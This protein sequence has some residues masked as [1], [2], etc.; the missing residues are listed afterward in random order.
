LSVVQCS[1]GLVI[2]VHFCLLMTAKESVQA[3]AAHVTVG[4]YPH[5]YCTFTD[6]LLNL[7][8]RRFFY[9]ADKDLHS[10]CDDVAKIWPLNHSDAL[11]LSSACEEV[12]EVGHAFTIFYWAGGS[13]C[14]HLHY[15]MMIPLY[16]ALY[17]DTPQFRG[18]DSEHVFMPTVETVRLQVLFNVA[19]IFVFSCFL[20]ILFIILN[21]STSDKSHLPVFSWMNN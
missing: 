7:S 17:H 13:N 12:H 19:S 18:P 3:D 4:H 2:I 6:V 21:I 20:H 10:A 5:L 16:A 11:S 14:F 1:T 8:E 15:D 9:R